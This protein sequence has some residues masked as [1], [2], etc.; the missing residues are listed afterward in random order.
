MDRMDVEDFSLFGLLGRSWHL[1]APVTGVTFD[2]SDSAVAYTLVDGSVAI[3]R[4]KDPEAAAKR[5]RISAEDG[6][7]S[8]LPRSRPP[9]PITRFTIQE[10]KAVAATAYGKHGFVL[11]DH[12][13]KLI[14]TTVGGERTP[15]AALENG[16]ITTLDHAAETGL[17]ACATDKQQIALVSRGTA[18]RILDHASPIGRLKF[19][20][21]G[22][23]LAVAEGKLITLW[24]VGDVPQKISELATAGQAIAL[25]W[26]PDQSSLASGYEKRGVV[27]WDVDQGDHQSFADYPSPVRSLTWSSDGQVLVTSGAFRVIAWPANPSKP[28]GGPPSPNAVETGKP[29]LVAVEAVA[30]HPKRPLIAAGYENG[31]LIIAT[32]GSRDELVIKTEGGGAITE[33]EWSGDGG[34]LAVGT[35]RG[36]AAIVELPPQ[37]FK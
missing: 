15:F 26:S 1:D 8:I 4:I 11:G 3:A 16:A 24:Q 31:M 33:L 25:A 20:P 7:S 27:I 34:Y 18:P 5:I 19:S 13:G 6:R 36:L 17:I 10:G 12:A 28:N 29:S 9:T 35:D 32:V 30:S 14:S 37:L 22:S 21:D 23:Q 2:N